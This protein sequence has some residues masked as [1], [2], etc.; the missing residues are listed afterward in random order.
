[1]QQ[2]DAAQNHHR[3]GI[4]GHLR[5]HQEDRRCHHPTAAKLHAGVNQRLG[6]PVARDDAIGLLPDEPVL[7]RAHAG[8]EKDPR[9]G[10]P[11]VGVDTGVEQKEGVPLG[12][13]HHEQAD[14]HGDDRRAQKGQSEQIDRILLVPRQRHGN[15]E[16]QAGGDRDGGHDGIEHRQ[17]AE[18][19]G[20][21]ELR[22]NDQRAEQHGLG[23]GGCACQLHHACK[24]LSRQCLAQLSHQGMGRLI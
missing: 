2:E 21:I 16:A 7:H 22:G 8:E 1:M 11:Q 23:Q 12:R 4:I 6:Y 10:E 20:R 9:P 17:D 3:G 14:R 5:Q 24:E 15:V 19:R 13:E 18:I